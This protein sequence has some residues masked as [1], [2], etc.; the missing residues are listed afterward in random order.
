MIRSQQSFR[1]ILAAGVAVAALSLGLA[2]AAVEAG[3][4]VDNRNPG[5]TVDLD[6]SKEIR[7]ADIS[8]FY[9]HDFEFPRIQCFTTP[10]LLEASSGSGQEM[11]MAGVTFVTVYEHSTYAGAY[12]HVSGDYD[13]LFWIGWNDRISSFKAKNGLSGYFAVDWYG[14]GSTWA[15]CCNHSVSNLGSYN[16]TFTSVYND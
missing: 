7:P 14:A 13:T 1:R 3:A 12:M 2:P 16:D 15:F 9:C 4:D 8:R 10:E 11:L 6:G 5:I